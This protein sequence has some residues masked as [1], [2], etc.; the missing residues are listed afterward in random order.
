MLLLI[1]RP[2]RRG[3]IVKIGSNE[4]E[5]TRIGI[6]SLSMRTWDNM[7]VIIPNSE[8]ITNAFVN[9]TH[10]DMIVRTVLMIGVSYDADPHRVKAVLERILNAHTGILRDPAPVALLWEFADSAVN[11]RIHYFIDVSKDSLFKIR[12]E[13]LFAIWDNF[14]KEGI[15]IPY[16]QRDLYIKAW[17]EAAAMPR[18]E[19]QGPGRMVVIG[20]S[21]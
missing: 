13:V 3:D 10:Q 4:G 2:L 15:A 11:F 5:I 6:R 18:S 1:E 7:E 16:P 12:G 9:W 21:S 17:P 14:K 19:E 8:V 20:Q